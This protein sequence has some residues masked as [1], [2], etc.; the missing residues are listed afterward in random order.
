M[1]VEADN[2]GRL[3]VVLDP[4]FGERLHDVRPDQPVWVAESAANTPVVKALWASP[5]YEHYLTDVTLFTTKDPG[6]ER[7]FLG[8]ID[9]IDLHNGPYSTEASYT[10]LEVVGVTLSLN[11]EGQLR[12]LG[13]TNFSTTSDGFTARRSEEEAKRLRRDL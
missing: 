10:C 11:I 3:L 5:R 6:G 12:A 4:S 7:G 8:Q 1:G 13:F 9:T 2:S